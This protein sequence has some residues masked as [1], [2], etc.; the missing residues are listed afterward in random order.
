M[1]R[2]RIPSAAHRPASSSSASGTPATTTDDGPLTAAIA[3]S[4][5]QGASS[6]RACTAGACR[7]IIAPYPARVRAIA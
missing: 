2:V 5:P 3:T 7:D 1:Q 6:S 4:A